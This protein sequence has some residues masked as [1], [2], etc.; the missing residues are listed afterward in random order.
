MMRSLLFGVNASDPA[1]YLLV[2]LLLAITA[3]LA[4]WIPARRA[5]RVDPMITLRAE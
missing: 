4:C 1:V 2:S 5:A 3:A